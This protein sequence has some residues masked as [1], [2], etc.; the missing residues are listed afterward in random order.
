MSSNVAGNYR[1]GSDYRAFANSQYSAA[2]ATN[3]ATCSN[4]DVSLDYYS[5][6]SAKVRDYHSTQSNLN[7]VA[8]F[9]TFRILILDIY[10]VAD[11][12]IAAD[13][14]APQAMQ[15]WTDASASGQDPREL[16]QHAIIHAP[17]ERFWR[18]AAAWW[19]LSHHL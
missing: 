13:R 10:I 18:D 15:A 14:D 3:Q 19:L 9:D 4:P 8:D 16:M 7:V 17:R 5:S 2:N 6:R 12:Y 1:S 11:K